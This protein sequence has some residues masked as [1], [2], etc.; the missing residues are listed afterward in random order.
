MV[1]TSDT[2]SEEN[3]HFVPFARRTSEE[4]NQS[5]SFRQEREASRE[6]ARSEHQHKVNEHQHKVNELARAQLQKTEK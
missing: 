4:N 6:R 5:Y 3:D 2:G 1:W